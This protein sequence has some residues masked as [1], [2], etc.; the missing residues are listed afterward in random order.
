MS[1]RSIRGRTLYSDMASSSRLSHA[2]REYRQG[3]HI[4]VAYHSPEEQLEVAVAYIADGL[5]KNEQCLYSVATREGLQAFG[6][7]LTEAGIDAR[8][9]A[10][11]GRL[12]LLTKDEAHLRPGYFDAEAMLHMLSERVEAALNEGYT[13]LRTCGDMSWLLDQAP[14]SDQIVEYEA[15]LNEF[16]RSVR[17]TGMCQYDA[18]RLP[19]GLLNHALDHHPSIVV[20]GTHRANPC[21]GE[22]AGGRSFGERLSSLRRESSV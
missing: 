20:E 6:K 7:A 9:A 17:A 18:T 14:G 19:D 2:G 1:A 5:N 12:I 4:C 13:G 22:G 15:L 10:R 3:D 8:E 11:T 16:F 21:Y